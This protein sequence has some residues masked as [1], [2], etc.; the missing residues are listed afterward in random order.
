MKALTSLC[1]LM[2]ASALPAF[3]Q[4]GM[5]NFADRME[6]GV[7]G[8]IIYAIIGVLLL[9]GAFKV[10][11]WLLPGKLSDQLIHDKNTAVAI[12]TG[13]FILGVAIIIAAAIKE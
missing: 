10:K 13:A 2:G 3:A 8:S 11:D 7:L 5:D 1:L 12:V 4:K 6:S 9:V